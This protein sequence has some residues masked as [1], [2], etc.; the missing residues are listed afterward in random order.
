MKSTIAWFFI[1]AIGSLLLYVLPA[2]AQ[3]NDRHSF[4]NRTIFQRI[5]QNDEQNNKAM[6]DSPGG[7]IIPLPVEF[8]FFTGFV[9]DDKKVNLQWQ[10]ASELNNDYFEI[11]RSTD[12]LQWSLIDEVKGNGTT[13][14]IT[15]YQYIDYSATDESGAYYFYRLKQVDLNG[16]SEYSSIISVNTVDNS[17]PQNVNV[18]INK[19]NQTLAVQV[20]TDN[21]NKLYVTISDMNGK[22]TNLLSNSVS[23]GVSLYSIPLNQIS[24]GF[25]VC[26]V[27]MGQKIYNFKLAGL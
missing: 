5:V 20:K 13:K 14:N 26:K 27:N 22:T 17:E 24:S 21:A 19:S 11:E 12:G 1:L 7:K 8:T 9:N 2:A 6:N 23:A 4:D 3:N 15:D 25:H 16:K 10:T 18:W